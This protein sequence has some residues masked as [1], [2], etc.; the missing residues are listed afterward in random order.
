MC[1]ENQP[2]NGLKAEYP[3]AM[4]KGGFVTKQPKIF[5]VN[6]SVLFTSLKILKRSTSLTAYLIHTLSCCRESNK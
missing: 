4:Q 6:L 2:K 5:I 1:L 3:S